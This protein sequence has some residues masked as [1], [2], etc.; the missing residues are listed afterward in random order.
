MNTLMNYRAPKDVGKFLNSSV[1]DGFS[2][3]AQLHGVGHVFTR[4]YELVCM[5]C[6]PLRSLQNVRS[7]GRFYD[8][9]PLVRIP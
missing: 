3:G 6:L 7:V 8:C 5:H 4:T 2:I 9:C 1:S